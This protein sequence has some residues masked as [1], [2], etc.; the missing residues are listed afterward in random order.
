MKCKDHFSKDECLGEWDFSISKVAHEA[1]KDDDDK[2]MKIVR[3]S[4]CGAKH[5]PRNTYS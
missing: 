3:C 5:Y 2:G 4:W 1:P